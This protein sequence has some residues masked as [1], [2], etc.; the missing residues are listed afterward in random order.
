MKVS[1][2]PSGESAGWLTESAKFVICTHSVRAGAAGLRFSHQKAPAAASKTAAPDYDRGDAEAIERAG[3]G[4]PGLEADDSLPDTESSLSS[5]SASLISPMCCARRSRVLAQAARDDLLELG[6]QIRRE[7]GERLRL[8]VQDCRK[9]RDPGCAFKWPAAG[10]HFVKH[11]AER[12]NIG[13]RIDLP[14]FGLL[15]RHVGDGADDRAFFGL[16]A[17]AERSCVA[18][19]ASESTVVLGQL[20]QT[21]IEQFYAAVLGDDDVGR[22]EIAMDDSGRV[23]AGEGVGNLNRIFQRVFQG[24]A[25]L[26]DQLVE[27]LAGDELHG[28]EIGA[29][30]RADVVNVDDVGVIQ[31]RGGL[32]LLHEAALALGAGGASARR[33][34]MATG[35][36]R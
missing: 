16:K 28:N 22:L 4:E 29:V 27:R 35:R 3:T 21:E 7:L 17:F 8:L 31:G 32:G 19:A 13:T 23:G 11:R 20:G 30:G 12:K 15:G 34:L 5:S 33:I 24:Q 10:D 2:R 25:A 14:A 18:V 1:M 26:A 36:S 9:R 6:G